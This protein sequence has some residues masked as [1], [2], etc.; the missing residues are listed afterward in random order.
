MHLAEL[1]VILCSFGDEP[2]LKDTI[3]RYFY[4]VLPMILLSID[5][6]IYPFIAFFF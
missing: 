6:E 4:L 5:E 2:N 3:Q 1:N